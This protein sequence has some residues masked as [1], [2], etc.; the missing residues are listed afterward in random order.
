[1]TAVTERGGERQARSTRR[2]ASLFWQY[3]SASA[4]SNVGDAVT[5][6][7]LPL[8]AVELL[9][10]SSFQVSWLTAAAYAAWILIGLPA[11]VIV[12][13]LPLRGA[14]VAMDLFRAAALASVPIAWWAGGL[15][16]TQLV[17]V[18][19]VVSLATVI[20]SVG[21]ATFL[22]AIVTKDQLTARNSVMSG[23][24]AVTQL[25]GP[26]LGG[27]LV[28]FFSAP[29]AL[30]VDVA[31]YL[32][33]AALLAGLPRPGRVQPER[34]H[35]SAVTLIKDGIRY[36][37]RHPVIGPCTMCAA[38]TNFVC[39]ALMALTPVFLVRTLGAP[40][41]LVGLLI[42]AEGLGSL[43]GAALTPRLARRMGTARAIMAAAIASTLLA[44]AMPFS[45]GSWGFAL[46]GIGN[47]GLASGV[48]VFSILT[49]TYRQTEAPPELF[50]RVMATVR[51]ISWGVI[52]FGALAAG[53]IASVAGNRTAMW[54]ACLVYFAA[55][56][57]LLLSK[58]RHCKDLTDGSRTGEPAQLPA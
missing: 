58:I 9:G 49:R 8:T 22:P 12:G 4:I 38:I 23:S 44:L 32:M 27:V 54:L 18:A 3:W 53:A 1:M 5:T 51:F 41:W 21:S 39:G 14:Q 42:A 55:P 13:R 11:G 6:V 52:P 24:V 47:A 19:L 7:A 33:S 48:V 56:C 31:S 20:S 57:S 26:S 17:L 29:V 10:A 40:A 36:V 37:V 25:G 43:V 28:Q 16:M 2:P 45:R 35:T 34:S 15:T 46:F 30:V 50:P